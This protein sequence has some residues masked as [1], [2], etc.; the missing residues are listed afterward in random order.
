LQL[1]V[2]VLE[3]GYPVIIDAAF[4]Q[5]AQRRPFQQLAGEMGLPYIILEFSASPAALRDRIQRRADDVSDADLSVLEQQLRSWEGLEPDEASRAIVIDTENAP[6][7]ETLL[8]K[9][10]AKAELPDR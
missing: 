9:I 1:A 10:Q 5:T 3:A 8:E 7:I 6:A 4:L 2:P